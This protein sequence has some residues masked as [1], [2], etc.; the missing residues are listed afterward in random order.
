MSAKFPISVKPLEQRKAEITH[1]SS[2]PAR[3]HRFFAYRN[4]S[5]DLPV[6]RLPIGLPVYR[7]GNYRTNILQLRWIKEKEKSPTFFSNGEEN[8]SVQKIQHDFL[9]DLAQAE[10]GSV[11]SI[12]DTLQAERQREPILIS[13]SGVIVNGNRRLAAMR[14]LYNESPEDYESFSH[15]DCMVLP[16]NASEDDLKDI[17]VRLQ[18]TPET[19]LPYG[20]INECMAIKDLRDRG[21]TVETIGSMMRMDAP[22]VKDKLL[23]L[24][25][26]DLYLKDWKK[27]ELD[28]ESLSD[29]EE[30]MLQFTSRIKKKEGPQ[31]E[32]SRRLSWIVLDQRGK[33]GRV[34]DLRDA[35][36]TLT[37]AV[38]AKLQEVYPT[39]MNL[40]ESGG[41]ADGDLEL[42]IEDSP[43][44][45]QN[46][47]NFLNSC[48]TDQVQ[49]EVVNVCRVIVEAQKATKAGGAAL[50]SA[51][52]SHTKLV[53]IDLTAADPSTYDAIKR[54]FDAIELLTQN[55]RTQLQ[56][57]ANP[58]K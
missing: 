4:E 9:W 42:V 43:N 10:K 12:I 48:K 52:D 1:E 27:A 35:A 2:V 19:R 21:R 51:K 50:K 3:T 6:V 55:L 8:E 34:Y 54:Q 29:A 38:V 45:E 49:Q 44:T 40:V 15:I 20:W 39:E 57:L 47:I 18:M 53:E 41:V 58:K 13:A 46:V 26:I 28:Y 33:E 16:Q 7:I 24:T 36:G 22:K 37:E 17:E 5:H 14:E 56:R 23:M 31:K 32:I 25:E 30:I 11:T